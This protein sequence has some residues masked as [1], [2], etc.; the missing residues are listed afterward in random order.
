MTEEIVSEGEERFGA[1]AENFWNEHIIDRDEMIDSYEELYSYAN[2]EH[3]IDN[4]KLVAV[5]S[6]IDDFSSELASK[7][8]KAGMASN[9]EKAMQMVYDG[10][11]QMD[12]GDTGEGIETIKRAYNIAKASLISFDEFVSEY[13]D[14]I[15]NSMADPFAVQGEDRSDFI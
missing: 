11:A 7:G 15:L 9:G 14:D 6:D 2:S 5:K 1:Q 13:S 10:L 8:D 12:G 3:N 4:T